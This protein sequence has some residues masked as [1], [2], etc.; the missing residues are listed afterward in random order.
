MLATYNTRLIFQSDSDRQAVLR[1]LEA[2]REAFNFCS[3]IHFGAEKNSLPELH[4]KFYRKFRDVNPEIPSQIVIAAERDCL[5]AYRSIKSNKREISEPVDKKR[6][7]LRLDGRTFSRKGDAL[8]I[9][10]CGPRVK[11]S[12]EKYPK[13]QELLATCPFA[14]PLLFEK[15][16]E[17]W[18][19]LS[20]ERQ[21]IPASDKPIALGV[22]LGVNRPFATSS[23]TV[24]KDR[25]YNGDK[26]RT[27]FNKR[28]LSAKCSKSAR[29]KKRSIR[30][31][32]RNKSLAQSHLL[33]NAII[34]EAKKAHCNVVVLEDLLGL[35]SKGKK[36]VSRAVSNKISQ[37]PFAKLREILTYKAP[38]QG[39]TVQCVNPAFTSQDDSRFPKDHTM[40]GERKRSRYVGRDGFVQDADVNA[41]R[42]IALRAK[43][44]VSFCVSD[45]K[46]Y[47][48]A[49]VGRPKDA[50][51]NPASHVY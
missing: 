46:T 34:S 14:D 48:Q 31:L 41:A 16:G 13:L 20:F 50:G 47:G 11:C 40:R 17:I 7:S 44:P 9:I 51:R 49:S 42:N 22:D 30:N 3:K 39:L 27:R 45:A 4:A 38:L 24:F 29:R 5:A 6:L 36:R 23:G 33:A 35:K 18:M 26:R 8:S 25:K 21:E 43:L 1:V 28:K 15:D 19:A 2:Q 10:S 32:E 12:W 37:V